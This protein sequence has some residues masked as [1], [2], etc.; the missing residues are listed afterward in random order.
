MWEEL[1]LDVEEQEG[2]GSVGRQQEDAAS[3]G[4]SR[5]SSKLRRA[6]LPI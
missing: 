2:L 3:E 5:R 4:A 6:S 1:E